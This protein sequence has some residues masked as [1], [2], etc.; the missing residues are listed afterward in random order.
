MGSSNRRDFLRTAALG[1]V[2]A[3]AALAAAHLLP[4]R[5]FAQGTSDSARIAHRKLGLTGYNVSEIGMGCMNM[6]DAELVH[7][8]IDNGINYIDTARGYQRGENEEVIGQ[9]M[10]T[11][12][13]KVFLTTKARAR[14]ADDYRNQ[15]ELSLKALQTDHVDLMLMHGPNS[16]NQ[17]LDEDTMKAFD[18]LKKKGMCRF[19]GVSVHSNQAEVLNALVESN[20][21]N[22]AL[23]GYNYFS[24]SD[25]RPAIERA[26]KAGIGIIA[27]KNLLNPATFPWSRLDDIRKDK[28][29]K[30]TATQALIKWVLDDPYVDTT[31]PGMT[32]FEQL[33]EDIAIMNLNMSFDDNHMLNHYSELLKDYY[34]RGVAGCTGCQNQ[35]PKGVKVCD[36]NRCLAYAYCYGNK[37]L[38]W[39]NYRDLPN[40]SKVESCHDCTE[41]SVKCVNGLNLTQNIKLAKELFS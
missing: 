33:K 16:R 13:D 21:W 20:F 23:V 40:S 32:S 19:V 4:R 41:C 15:L 9:V 17:V 36:L 2:S 5:I 7:A 11:K 18:E 25:V 14:N 6:R 24:P 35:C 30:I 1:G 39:E 22:A 38:A 37:E 27:M 8:A 28:T 29:S 12:R 31:V 3:T 26:R 10:K 34:C